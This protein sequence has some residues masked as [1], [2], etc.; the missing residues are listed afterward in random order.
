[1]LRTKTLLAV[2]VA[3]VMLVAACTPQDPEFTLQDQVRAEDREDV[4]PE[5]DVEALDDAPVITFVAIDIDFE[6]H[7][8]EA[9]AGTVV[10]ELRNDGVVPHDVTI[11][12]LGDLI[13][14]E[15]AGGQTE[16]GTVTLE[17]GTYSFYCAVP[18]H[19]PAGMEGTLTVTG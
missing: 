13:V 18:G 15:A 19:R 12:E 7:Q 3:L 17:P 4:E 8:M 11:E 2:M 6:E 5:T 1:M 16:T 14:V 9:P 10:F